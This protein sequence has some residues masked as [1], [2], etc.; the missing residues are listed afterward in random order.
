MR[1]PKSALGVMPES[2]MM[3]PMPVEPVSV[4]EVATLGNPSVSRSVLVKRRGRGRPD[5]PRSAFFIFRADAP[6]AVDIGVERERRD[7]VP[8]RQLVDVRAVNF[9]NQRVDRC[10]L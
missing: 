1:P 5:R 10:V 3:T 8:A 7:F 2:M 6:S 4:E 9:G